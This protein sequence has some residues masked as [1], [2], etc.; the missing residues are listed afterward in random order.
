MKVIANIDNY[1]VLVEMTVT[2]LSLFSGTTL[3]SDDFRV[4]KLINADERFQQLNEIATIP[5]TL[6]RLKRETQSALESVDK[7]IKACE[8]TDFKIIKKR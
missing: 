2:E 6:Q 1:T 3:R 4:G 7:A 8:K 5:D